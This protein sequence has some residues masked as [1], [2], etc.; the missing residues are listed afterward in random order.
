MDPAANK[1]ARQLAVAKE[2]ALKAGEVIRS[3]RDRAQATV[4]SGVDLVTEVDTEVEKLVTGMLKEKFPS[5]LIIG[6]EDQA[7]NASGS[8]GEKIPDGNAWCIDPM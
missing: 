1:Y 3:S 2:A 8:Q 7:K 6:E 4:K 5:D